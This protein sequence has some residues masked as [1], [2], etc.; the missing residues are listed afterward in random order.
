MEKFSFRIA[1]LPHEAFQDEQKAHRCALCIFLLSGIEN[2][3]LA[4]DADSMNAEGALR[5][6]CVKLL[7]RSFFHVSL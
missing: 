3:S 7:V 6:E 2:Q 4:I 5:K 1:L